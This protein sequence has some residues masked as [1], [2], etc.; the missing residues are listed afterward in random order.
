M[1]GPVGIV[2]MAL[3]RAPVTKPSARQ[4]GRLQACLGL[5]RP[6][7]CGGPAW[8]AGRPLRCVLAVGYESQEASSAV[9]EPAF[10]SLW[11]RGKIT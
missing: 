8:P 5:S 1:Q 3:W 2:Y 10:G 11:S 4:R 6:P 9:P 7:R